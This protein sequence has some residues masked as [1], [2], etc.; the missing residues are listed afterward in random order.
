[1]T[2]RHFSGFSLLELLVVVFI[3]G[4]LVTMFTLSIG[5][6][7]GDPELQREVDRLQSVL[8]LASE[9]AV[10]QGRE[11]GMRFYPDGYEFASF[12]EDFVE[13][14]NPDDEEDQDKSEWT[15][16]GRD[17]ILGARR[18]PEDI[19]LELE[20]DG[21]SVVLDRD[22]ENVDAD[23][24]ENQYRPQVYLF[25][26]GD[27]SPFIVQLRRSY[28]NRG[29]IIEVNVDGTVELTESN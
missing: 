1:M 8:G 6:T 3:V 4:V 12:Y 21:R 24:S 14:R 23:E 13:Y 28:Q 11:M 2:R 15:V 5:I 25:S 17:G 22:K 29:F 27:I 16:V 18:L 19:V 9:E 26:S 20:I 7:G 10:M